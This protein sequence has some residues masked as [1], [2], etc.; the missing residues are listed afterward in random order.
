M[1]ANYVNKQI[2]K[3]MKMELPNGDS[4]LTMLAETVFDDILDRIR[5]SRLNFQLQISPYSAYISLKKS[6]QKDRSGSLLVPPRDCIEVKKLSSQNMK[7]KSD[8]EKTQ[9]ELAATSVKLKVLESTLSVKSESKSIEEEILKLQAENRILIYKNAELS[10]NIALQCSHFNKDTEFPKAEGKN[11][12]D[13]DAKKN[14]KVRG[15]IQCCH[16]IEEES[17]LAESP[18]SAFWSGDTVAALSNESSYGSIVPSLVSHWFPFWSD[19]DSNIGNLLSIPSL[20]SH[21]VR[22]PD[23][24]KAFTSLEHVEYEFRELLRAKRQGQ[25]CK[26]S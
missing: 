6:L 19:K 17:C 20:R 3:L 2:Y 24:G 9:E 25:D 26:L 5:N 13:I 1:L 22:L 11:D 16:H 10:K 23:P 7:L 21:Y 18:S 4:D 12:L 8:L 15:L 14:L